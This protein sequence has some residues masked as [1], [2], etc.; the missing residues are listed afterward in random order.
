[1]KRIH[2]I[3]IAS[4]LIALSIAVHAPAQVNQT[5]QT[6]LADQTDIAVTIYNNNLALVRDRRSVMLKTGEITLK[7]MDVAQQ[8]MPETVSLAS[9]SH[10]GA[11]RILEQ[12]YEYDLMSPGKM[13]E[14]YIGK[15]VRLV[16]FSTELGFTEVTAELLSTN[17]GN[18][19]RVGDEIF[20]GHPG[21]VVLPEIPE[22]L[23]AKPSLIWTLESKATKQDIEAT[24]LTHGISWRADYVITMDEDE[25]TAAIAAWVTLNN[26]S[27][28]TYKDAVLKVV[29]GDVNITQPQFDGRTM[30]MAL[31]AESAPMR[32]ESFAE[33]H[34]YTLPRRTT[35]KQNQSKQ[36]SLFT[37]EGVKTIKRYEFRGNAR[38]YAQRSRQFET[39]NV[40]VFIEFENRKEYQLGVPL[41]AGIMRIYQ[42]DSEGM[43]QFAGEDRI[44]HTAKDERIRLRMGTAFDVVGERS[45]TDYN[46][47]SNQLY[48]SAYEIKIRNHK[49]SA[50]SVD[51]VE[52]MAGDWTILESS[53]PFEK[54]DAFTAVFS[55]NV[56]PDDEATLTYRIRVRY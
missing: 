56:E 54:K 43:L 28:A 16:N 39:Q 22:D 18:V 48:E 30:K 52:P 24:Y 13:M 7:F 4:T 47:L 53:I 25:T 11:L 10:P 45:Q 5:S 44:K 29:A 42:P 36:V 3:R 32:E 9:T 8:I 55:L 26:Q 40:D 49:E 19:Y 15:N 1:M 37:A 50:V 35:I 31:R 21:Y 51:V 41:P 6:G 14:K 17:Q 23:I 46:K 12:N 34:L 27:G 38:Y 33:F 2:G 20:L